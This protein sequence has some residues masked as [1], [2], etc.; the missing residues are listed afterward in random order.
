ME[1]FKRTKIRIKLLLAFGSVIIL[2]VL[3]TVYA[4]YSINRI[5]RIEDLNKASE[6]LSIS[7]EQVELA[8]NTFI[9]EGYK[10]PKFQESERSDI[11]DRVA[12]ALHAANEQLTYLATS[13]YIQ[14]DTIKK[15]LIA[16]QT[17]TAI[18]N[19]FEEIKGLLKTRGFKDYG[20]EGS[21]R[22]AIHK[23]E[24]SSL[25]Y[26]RALMLTLRRHEKDFFLRKDLK[27]QK[28]FNET[29]AYFSASLN[30]SN[31]A[32]L[33][34]LLTNYQSEFNQVVE[35][36]KKI[37]LTANE[38]KKGEL[39][40]N[41][42]TVRALVAGI[43]D[44]VYDTTSREIETSKILLLIIFG[45][46]LI[47]AIA[48]AITY[49]H[50]LTKTIKEI[51]FTMTQL[52]NGLFPSPLL[53]T[54]HEE[55]GQTKIAINQFLD[56]LKVA[57]DFAGKL[58]NG[59]LHSAYDNR[60]NNDVFAQA[61]INMQQKLYDV[62]QAQAK[63]NWTNKGLAIFNEVAN[64]D[65]EDLATIG[66]N[67]IRLLV[68]YL[69]VNQGALY[70]ANSTHQTFSR[71]STFAYGKK[72]FVEDEIPFGNGLIGQCALEQQT[73]VLKEIPADYVKITS[74]LGSALPSNIVIAPLLIRVEVMGVLELA[75]FE[76]FEN[77]HIIFIEK[78]A[79][80]IAFILV[81]RQSAEHTKILLAEAETKTK[82]LLEREE[83]I[84]QNAEELL[85]TQEE[86]ERQR[87]EMQREINLLK[88][89]AKHYEQQFA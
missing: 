82:E 31:N 8:A 32:E 12:M 25:P 62:E 75:S 71:L 68:Q 55:I 16:L 23:I 15:Q 29:I 76:L 2:S 72:K 5:L 88:E 73:L 53:V 60:Y 30:K 37:G 66:D 64:N 39:Y 44:H 43:H 36:E 85:A 22:R 26:D 49:S 57:T 17:S 19:G 6:R 58:G 18:T 67:I 45:V 21:L 79:E 77:H 28:E 81:N 40:E 70:I 13:T 24:K 61:L 69:Q 9:F 56:R 51:K 4:L 27:Y 33:L 35:I 7:L 87:D 11:T 38:G 42:R 46:Q 86:M 41:M 52:A 84:R 34:N 10:D 1:F 63:I 74:G 47:G 89:K 59:E 65:T 3:L 14:N 48:L 80:S 78:I 20:L 83:Q 50:S 54:T